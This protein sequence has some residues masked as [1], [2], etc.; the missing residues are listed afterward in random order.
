MR[1]PPT[2]AAPVGAS[3]RPDGPRACSKL[4]PALPKSSHGPSGG[5]PGS[6]AHATPQLQTPAEQCTATASRED[7]DEPLAYVISVCDGIG[8]ALVAASRKT[9]RIRG[10]VCEEKPNL[11][12]FTR[13]KWPL[14]TSSARIE[15]LTAADLF[16][17]I[18]AADP[19]LVILIG[20]P[21]CQPYSGLATDPKGLSDPRAAP[22][23][24]FVRLREELREALVG[25]GIQFFWLLEE[26]ASMS[27]AHRAELTQLIGAEPVLLH[28][29]DFGYMH[30]PR[31]YFGLDIP[32][33]TDR[34]LMRPDVEV[35]KADTAAKGLCVVRYIGP[36]KPPDW[37]PK[38]GFEWRFRDQCGVRAAAAP[39]TGYAP[40]FPGGR[41]LT[42]VTAFPHPADRPPKVRDDPDVYQRFVDDDRMQPLYTY[43]KGNMVWSGPTARPIN[44][45]EA[46]ELLGFPSSYT[47]SL[48]PATGQTKRTARRHAL[49][50]TFHV[51]SIVLLMSLLVLPHA[52]GR[53]VRWQN[54]TDGGCTTAQKQE[55]EKRHTKGTVW[56]AT[57][58]SRDPDAW[59]APHILQRALNLFPPGLFGP[60]R[61]EAS[62][63]QSVMQA[64]AYIDHHELTD[65]QAYLAATGAPASATGPDIQALWSKSPMHAAAGKQH[66]ASGT[67]AAQTNLVESGLGPHGHVTAAMHVTHP[68]AADPVL[69]RDLLFVIEAYAHIGPAIEARRRRR[70]HV[71]R[72]IARATKPL[73][74]HALAQR[75][76]AVADAPGLK[77]VFVAF[78]VIMMRWPDQG[79]P[80]RLV[81]GFELTGDLDPSGVHRPIEPRAIGHPVHLR[82]DEGLLGDDAKQFVDD[83]VS[84][85]TRSPLT[86]V[87]YE[88]TEQEVRDGLADTIR[89]R[90]YF[91]EKY[92]AGGW[93]CQ[94][95]HATWQ[96]G[97]YRPIDDGRR[98]RTNAHAVSSEALVATPSELVIIMV[99]ALVAAILRL[100]PELPAWLRLMMATEDWWK[101]FRQLIPTLA[102]MAV[103][104]AAV[105]CPTSGEWRFAQL[106][107]LPF[108]LGAAVTQ[109]G[110]PA[111]FMTAVA[112][113]LLY[114]MAGHYVD[115]TA[116]LELTLMTA[117]TQRTFGD[118][119][120]L[121]GVRL[122]ASKRQR[123][124]SYSQFLGHTHDLG[125]MWTDAAVVYGPKPGLR[126]KICAE[127]ADI[128]SCGRLSSGR[129]AKL[130]GVA[131]WIDTGLSGRC[132]RGAM[133]ALVA[134]QYYD[135]ATD[136]DGNLLLSLRYIAAAA[137]AQPDRCV[138]IMPGCA[139][140]VL[141]WTDASADAGGV[142]IGALIMRPGEPTAVIIYD[143]P[144]E[145]V[146][147]W[148]D[149]G[150]V[151]NQAELHAAPVVAE[152]A[153]HLIADSEVIWW[154]D[155]TSAETSLIKAGSPTTTMCALALVA[156]AC[157]ARLRARPWFEHIDSADNP[158][159][160]L[161]RAGDRDPEVAR[162]L[163]S[164]EWVRLPAREPPWERGLDFSAS[165]GEAACAGDS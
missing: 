153:G 120:G 80:S 15:D 88:L 131:M 165:W 93:R 82:P 125:R 151:I 11:R 54:V 118:M 135:D 90:E 97:K 81:Y 164:G 67:V 155:N 55:W 108:G 33:L 149:G 101:G 86:A 34:P 6:S 69:E 132:C 154:I 117:A 128:I 111:A 129:A 147:L 57:Q 92:G 109:F 163:S 51:P 96:S 9:T 143:P 150:T 156:T 110:R 84:D 126:E 22:L 72:K 58:R 116:L 26:V 31:I 114:I 139:P 133:S 121:L 122:S 105:L 70:L 85:T 107:G 73:D 64:M 30:R 74:V 113:R 35:L 56:D 89:R 83:L 123:F 39:G 2:V 45:E 41:F 50:N 5:N 13:D 62:V 29:A 65:F 61:L 142:R 28:A 12:R 18:M 136:V 94:P 20:G 36:P 91:D 4:L 78:L 7:P 152:S 161:S 25:T 158:A 43:A 19:D 124:A 140:P 112:R 138:R 159:D 98:S 38:H 119:A 21:P 127:I 79:L 130:R 160:V 10:H 3:V 157:F 71:L 60:P 47:S 32:A 37:G 8:A 75:H 46:E 66:R 49:G 134:R 16:P 42:L 24:H 68:F 103:C 40:A 77:P 104:I 53:N 59:D 76:T 102:D 1:P 17:L 141:V 44:E 100:V 106:R 146:E 145:V 95:R 148:G 162:R 137:A 144:A 23:R 115:D 27:A 48:E 63:V 87:V 99:R 14:C 52:E